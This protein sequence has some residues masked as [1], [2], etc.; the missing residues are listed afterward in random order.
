MH[1]F[2]VR[3]RDPIGLLE[4]RDYLPCTHPFEVYPRR[5][6]RRRP[7][8]HAGG[9]ARREGGRHP[10]EQLGVGTD[11]R[12]LREHQPGDPLR[13]IAWKATVRR[14]KLV[15]KNFEHETSMSVCLM[16]DVSCSMRGGQHPGQKLEHGIETA[17][18]MADGLSRTATRSG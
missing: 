7:V 9:L 4:T 8:G 2:D 17:V 5:I 1:G 18:A 15:S 6:A 16:L 10:V 14:G 11:V 12:E 13:H 3:V